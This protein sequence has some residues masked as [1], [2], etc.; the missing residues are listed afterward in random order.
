M[1]PHP[2][3]TRPIPRTG[4]RIPAVGLGTWQAFD[5][6]RDGPERA[7]AKEALR[8]LAELGGTVVDSS[9]MYGAAEQAVG[10]LSAE[11]G[12]AGKLF[13]ATKVW[14][15]GR[16][17]GI[18]Q[19]EASFAKLG[20]ARLDLMQVHNL[21]DTDTH[22]ATLAGW[23]KEGRVRYL[24]VTHYTASGHAGLEAAI[25][26]HRPDFVQL[27]HSVTERE[28][29]RRLLPLAQDE[30]VAVLVNRPVGQG[31]LFARVKGRALP[32]WADEIDCASWAQVFLKFIL[33]HPAVT[34]V[35]PGTRNAQHLADNLGAA[36]GR[37][38][39][40]ALRARMAAYFDSL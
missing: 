8:T 14:T 26:A 17:A 31:R 13:V 19:M 39:D 32:A 9:P 4:E 33:G 28:A 15:S 29:E 7:A 3:E 25:K 40:A 16:D 34:C 10:A 1:H 11:L 36:R 23:R 12:L 18:R 35:I 6:P 24:G 20:V 30:G 22:L 38:P 37:L 27:N 21:V 5:V 2:L